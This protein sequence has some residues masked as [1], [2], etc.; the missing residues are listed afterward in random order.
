MLTHQKKNNQIIQALILWQ[1]SSLTV[2]WSKIRSLETLQKPGWAV[3][4]IHHDFHFEL[5]GFHVLHAQQNQWISWRSF[6]ETPKKELLGRDVSNCPWNDWDLRFLVARLIMCYVAASGSTVYTISKLYCV[7]L[8]HFASYL[9]EII[10]SFWRIYI[11]W[12]HIRSWPSG[13][14]W[15]SIMRSH[16]ET[17]PIHPKWLQFTW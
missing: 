5:Q 10:Q 2:R 9:H 8:A 12:S 4:D 11:T 15:N 13:R 17:P 14:W 7:L 3:P 1:L 6:R 16:H